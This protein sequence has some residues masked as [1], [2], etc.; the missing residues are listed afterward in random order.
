MQVIRNGVFETNSSS[1]HSITIA[2]FG[3]LNDAL[4]VNDEICTIFPG[5]FG[6]EWED[7]NDAATK[8][9]YCLTYC[10][11]LEK[12]QGEHCTHIQNQSPELLEQLKRV[13]ARH[14]GAK[15]V[16]YQERID[17]FYPWGYIDHQSHDTCAPA[18]E[19]DE[20]LAMFIFNKN[21][22]LQTGND[23]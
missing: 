23:N 7:F 20:T 16:H 15:E 8:A 19:T 6:W 12:S 3:E 18:F 13:I 14:T 17:Q 21:S 11:S 1:T 9:S 10:K 22:V 4:L 5:E 2:G